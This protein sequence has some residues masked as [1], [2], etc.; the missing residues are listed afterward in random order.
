MMTVGDK[1]SNEL[2]RN[3]FIYEAGRNESILVYYLD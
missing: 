1:K 2:H 3:E